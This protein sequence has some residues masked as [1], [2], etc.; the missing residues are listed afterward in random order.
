MPDFLT[1]PTSL[2]TSRQKVSSGRPARSSASVTHFS[3]LPAVVLCL[4]FLTL[5]C[6]FGFC[7]LSPALE[8]N[9]R[10]L[11]SC[12]APKTHAWQKC[13]SPKSSHFLPAHLS[14]CPPYLTKL[15]EVS[16]QSPCFTRC[17]FLERFFF[18]LL[19]LS[20]KTYTFVVAVV[21]MYFF[22]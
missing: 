15:L 10:E 16:F 1:W 17:S 22:I 20:V 4:A 13:T 6:L 8:Q 7:Y 11:V 18:P 21:K 2:S 12:S 5:I 14:S 3:C 9:L 19:P